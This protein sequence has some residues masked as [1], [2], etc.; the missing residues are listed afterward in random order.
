MTRT[1]LNHPGLRRAGFTLVELMLSLAVIAIIGLGVMFMLAGTQASAQLQEDARLRVTREQV[2]M[3]RLGTLCRSN[4]MVLAV[5]AT[6][7]VFWKGDVNGNGKADLAELR[8]LEWSPAAKQIWVSE[9]PEDL[10]PA[11][12]TTYP[13]NASFSTI[14]SALAGSSTFPTRVVLDDITHWELTLDEASPQAA[15]L[16][17]IETR[18]FGSSNAQAIRMIASLRA[19]GS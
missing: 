15:R 7:L 17:K 6:H 18:F 1:A 12:N 19:R 10:A 5:D 14:T 3:T 16:M 4:A 9:A 13:L 2:A 11:S 8:R